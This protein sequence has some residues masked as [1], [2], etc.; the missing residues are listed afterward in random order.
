MP[1]G[2]TALAYPSPHAGNA[3]AHCQGKNGLTTDLP[4]FGH[5]R[6]HDRVRQDQPVIGLG[7]GLALVAAVAN[8]Q[9]VVQ[10]AGEDQQSPDREAMR[11]SLLVRLARR[12]RWLGGAAL[13]VVAGVAQISA[14]AFA[15]IAVVQP[16][17]SSSQLVLLAIARVRL[18]ERVGRWEVA[19]AIA[20]MIGLAAV[21]Y[22][23]PHHSS[24]MVGAGRLA[25]PLALVTGAALVAYVV[26]RVRPS[27]RLLLVIGA[28]LAYA[29]AD[30]VGKLLSDAVSTGGWWLV[31]VWIAVI[32]VVGGAAFL[33]ETTAL[34]HR[35]A[36]TV[37]PVIGAVK[38]PLCRC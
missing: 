36:V 5:R 27:L 7:L 15:P 2:L 23:A 1:V 3:K 24:V 17:L 10:Q 26:G 21:V 16:T 33:E 14:L 35:P 19:G 13:M 9:A 31:G 20:I 38:V 37:A 25:P 29:C 34:Q 32:V 28:G 18:G 4:F 22:A 12:P 11:A 6:E 30:F 8:A